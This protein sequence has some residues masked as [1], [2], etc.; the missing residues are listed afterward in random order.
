M[1]EWIRCPMCDKEKPSTMFAHYGDSTMRPICKRCQ[2]V[3]RLREQRKS[4]VVRQDEHHGQRTK[5]TRAD[6][7]VLD[8]AEG[9]TIDDVARELGRTPEGVLWQI[10]RMGRQRV[11]DG[12][13]AA[14]E[15]A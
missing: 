1:T 5:W 14:R 6:N 4:H 2:T 8:A 11:V 3:M 12:R 10:R 15:M 13:I 7:E 9:R